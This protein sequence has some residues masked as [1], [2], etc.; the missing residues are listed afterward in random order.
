MPVI[1]KKPAATLAG[2]G[3]RTFFRIAEKWHLNNAQQ[4]SLL[5]VSAPSTFFKWRKEQ[6][7]SLPRDVLERISY[8]LGVYKALH[9]LFPDDRAAD[10]WVH[11]PNTAP[12]FGG[13]PALERMLHGNVGDLYI[14]RQYLDAMRGGWA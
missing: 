13:K 8:V 6:P 11:R 3:R 1:A 2:A 4:M 9:T 10:S 12:M 7:D 5:G 14:V